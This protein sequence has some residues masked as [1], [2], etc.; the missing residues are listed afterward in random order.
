V[1]TLVI[2]RSIP[3]GIYIPRDPLTELFRLHPSG[4]HLGTL[5]A[6]GH[7]LVSGGS[8][9]G[10]PILHLTGIMKP[11]HSIDA[12]LGLLLIRHARPSVAVVRQV[13]MSD[14]A[15]LGQ[16]D[17]TNDTTRAAV[18]LDGLL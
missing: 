17:E 12:I 6:Y 8:T 2:P 9:S 13:K 3:V 7:A 10:I 14:G 11:F 1:Y 5:Y 18:P 15:G 4:P 16:D